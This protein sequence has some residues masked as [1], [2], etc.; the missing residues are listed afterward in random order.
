MHGKSSMYPIAT[1]GREAIRAAV[2]WQMG[3]ILLSNSFWM[4]HGLEAY[5]HG[6]D[7]V[8]LVDLSD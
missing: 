1:S 6:L 2:L 8:Q 5:I 3:D 4:H 7:R